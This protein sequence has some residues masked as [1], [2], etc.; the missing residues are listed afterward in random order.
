MAR[1]RWAVENMET[2]WAVFSEAKMAKMVVTTVWDK[3]TES[4]QLHEIRQGYAPIEEVTR[5]AE[6][7]EAARDQGRIAGYQVELKEV[8]VCKVYG[9]LPSGTLPS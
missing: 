8:D 4:T 3:H 1:I 2:R 7:C 6:I 9:P 5:W